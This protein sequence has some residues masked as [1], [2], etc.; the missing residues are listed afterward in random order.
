MH[1]HRHGE[2]AFKHETQRET[3]S[4]SQAD[5]DQTQRYNRPG[6]V[7][8]PM[9]GGEATTSTVCPRRWNQPIRR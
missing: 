6:G 1:A 4:L 5:G 3:D 8:P 2:P 9:L 7:V